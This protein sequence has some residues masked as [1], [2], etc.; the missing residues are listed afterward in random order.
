MA[1]SRKVFISYSSR[2]REF[3]KILADSIARLGGDASLS[4]H[5]AVAQGDWLG[6]LR[7][8]LGVSDAVVLIMPTSAARSANST[9]FE[10]GAARALGKDV[11]VVIPDTAAIDQANIPYDLASTIVLD[12][13]KKPIDSVAMTVMK[14]AA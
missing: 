9:F 4:E 2:D 11:I 12:A 13:S 6:N 1:E 10:A 14:T 8:K 7:A 5:G 3:A